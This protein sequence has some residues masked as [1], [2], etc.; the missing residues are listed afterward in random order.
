MK[1]LSQ[2]LLAFVLATGIYAESQGKFI[3]RLDSSWLSKTNEKKDPNQCL[4]LDGPS[5]AHTTAEVVVWVNEDG[6]TIRTETNHLPAT[7]ELHE[8][9]S[10]I[11]CAEY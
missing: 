7:S 5:E 9:V 3:Y 2:A 6:H 1:R 10:R 11:A 8:K 4:G